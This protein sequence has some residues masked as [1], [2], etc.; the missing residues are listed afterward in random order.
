MDC[1]RCG[2]S[3]QIMGLDH[4]Y[5]GQC[6][7][8]VITPLSKQVVK[9]KTKSMSGATREALALTSLP[10]AMLRTPSTEPLKL[11]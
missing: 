7:D 2:S 8:W 4:S 11:L 1:P 10:A 3:F 6:Q 5:C 9:P